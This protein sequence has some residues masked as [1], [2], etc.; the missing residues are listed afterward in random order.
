MK[1]MSMGAMAALS[2]GSS[3]CTQAQMEEFL[4]KRFREMTEAEKKEV[5]QRLEETYLRKY[6]KKFGI[7]AQ[8][9]GY[10]VL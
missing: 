10:G 9:A 6:G 1:M 2:L 8:P 3:S 5:I 4:Q 7:S